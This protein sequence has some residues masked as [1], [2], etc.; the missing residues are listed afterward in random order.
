METTHNRRLLYPLESNQIHS[1]KQIDFRTEILSD[2][3]RM[4]DGEGGRYPICERKGEEQ[5][6]EDGN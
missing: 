2:G 5:A 3:G 1:G 4:R 6:R